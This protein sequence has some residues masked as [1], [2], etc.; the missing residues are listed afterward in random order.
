MESE[1]NL[2]TF[3]GQNFYFIIR[4]IYRINFN[5]LHDFTKFSHF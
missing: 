1:G 2:I 5:D 3:Q 4:S